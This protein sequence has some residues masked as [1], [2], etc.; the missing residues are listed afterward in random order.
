L[1]GWFSDERCAPARLTVEKLGPSNPDCSATC[2][3]NGAAAVFISETGREI[4]KVKNHAG[5]ID[6]LGYHVAVTGTVDRE[7]HTVTVE[8]V[9]QLSYDGA[10]CARPRKPVAVKKNW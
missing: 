4:L 9:K 6:D 8:S 2:I 7:T 10:A 5:V 1:T 3:K